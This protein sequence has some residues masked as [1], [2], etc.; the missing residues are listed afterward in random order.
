[1]KKF[2]ICLIL[3]ICFL[4]FVNR[5]I[6][7]SSPEPSP[8]PTDEVTQKVQE[9][10]EKVLESAE[11]KSKRAYVGTLK[12]IS[13][14]TLTIETRLGDFQIKVVTDA[15]ILNQKREEIELGDLELGSKIIAMG[16]LNEQNVLEVKRILV[17]EKF[18]TPAVEVAFGIVTDISKDEKV[19]TVKHPKKQTIYMVEVTNNTKITKKVEGKIQTVK[20]SDIKENDRLVAIGKPGLNEEKIITAKLIHVIPGKAVGQQSP[21]PTPVIS[22]TPEVEEE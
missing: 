6:A 18:Q 8:S 19:L 14:S 11:E 5:V 12:S 3:T 22:P 16:F 15:V 2:T 10:M 13:N 9:R 1:M 4:F 21:S 20:F 17:I 7:Q